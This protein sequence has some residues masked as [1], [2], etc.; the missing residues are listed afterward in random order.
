MNTPNVGT[1][2]IGLGTTCV[3]TGLLDSR[4]TTDDDSLHGASVEIASQSCST[5][6]D[7]L[8]CPLRVAELDCPDGTSTVSIVLPIPES[9]GPGQPSS[10]SRPFIKQCFKETTPMNL[11][12]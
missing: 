2:G 10:T 4:S 9:K 3:N 5:I 6:A 12:K 8:L 11:P 7:A 1:A